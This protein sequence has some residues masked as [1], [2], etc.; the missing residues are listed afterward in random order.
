[1]LASEEGTVLTIEGDTI[2]LENAAMADV[3]AITKPAMTYFE[4]VDDTVADTSTTT[5]ITA[6]KIGVDNEIEVSGG[7]LLG[8][9][10]DADTVIKLTTI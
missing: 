6:D 9:C 8:D 2:T 3:C 10:V 5:R 4:I 7:G 1:M